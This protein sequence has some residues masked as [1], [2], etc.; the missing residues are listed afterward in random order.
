MNGDECYRPAA[1]G[2]VQT[3]CTQGILILQRDSDKPKY[4]SFSY[5]NTLESHH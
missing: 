2:I 3:K 4:R 5:G 1:V